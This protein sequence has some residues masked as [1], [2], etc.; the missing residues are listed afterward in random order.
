MI[1]FDES[2]TAHTYIV[3]NHAAGSPRRTTVILPILLCLDKSL[4]CVD[5]AI[6]IEFGV[7]KSGCLWIWLRCSRRVCG[8]LLNCS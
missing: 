5:G 2:E 7:M 8:F 3:G 4:F 1:R 6:L